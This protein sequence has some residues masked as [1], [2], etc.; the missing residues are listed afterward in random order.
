MRIAI[1]DDNGDVRAFFRDCIAE[2][3][4]NAHTIDLFGDPSQ[5]I[6]A[7]VTGEY[8]LIF[9]DIVF[10]GSEENGINVS[11]AILS[12]CPQSRIVYI[13]GYVMEFVDE[14]FSAVQPYGFISKPT[15]AER[16]YYYIDKREAEL[17][18]S[19]KVLRVS[20]SGVDHMI[21]L[22]DICYIES[23]MRQLNI[24]T[25]DGEGVFYGTIDSLMPKL[26]E[27]FLRCHQSFIVNMDCIRRFSATEIRMSAGELIPV[28]RSRQAETKRQYFDYTQ[29]SML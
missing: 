16:L 19:E 6:S 1:C 29:R 24:H 27:R 22:R 26:D 15:D 14:I 10:D 4:D 11:R 7:E 28:S 17:N 25:A 12:K 20:R 13:T 3:Y 8:D 2:R 21:F 18:R 23:S 5:I 9:L